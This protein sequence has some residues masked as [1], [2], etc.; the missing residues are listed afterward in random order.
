MFLI[1]QLL[2]SRD[3]LRTTTEKI[4]TG[5]AMRIASMLRVTSAIAGAAMR[6]ASM[7]RV[8]ESNHSAL[9]VAA[10]CP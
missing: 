7:L 8:H 5:A 2:Q 6:M 9:R 10:M 3:L 4:M 1:S